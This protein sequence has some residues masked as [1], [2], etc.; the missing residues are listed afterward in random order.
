MNPLLT[1]EHVALLLGVSAETVHQLVSTGELSFYAIGPEEIP[2]FSEAQVQA[3]LADAERR[4]MEI[5]EQTEAAPV[6]L[7]KDGP[8]KHLNLDDEEPKPKKVTKGS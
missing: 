7:I 1:S 8:V 3:Y 6:P 5:P 4:M 2:R